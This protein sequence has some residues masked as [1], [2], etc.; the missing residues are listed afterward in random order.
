MTSHQQEE[1]SLFVGIVMDDK[2]KY[3]GICC[4]TS[5]MGRA[6]HL[7]KQYNAVKKSHV[8]VVKLDECKFECFDT[9]IEPEMRHM[10]QN[11][12]G[13]E[14]LNKSRI[15]Y[16]TRTG[17]YYPI[18]KKKGTKE[19]VERN[20]VNSQNFDRRRV[21]LDGEKYKFIPIEPTE[22]EKVQT[23]MEWIESFFR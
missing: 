16:S 5:M 11:E 14:I 1:P 12:Y 17:H 4:I 2:S 3:S 6:A 19:T 10:D 8:I 21:E 20:A 22:K 9:G 23:W 15:C 7:S 13:N 18:F